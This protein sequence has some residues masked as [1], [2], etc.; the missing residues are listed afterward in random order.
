MLPLQT[1]KQPRNGPPAMACW[2][3]FHALRPDA[4]AER[5]GITRHD[6]RLVEPQ[7]QGVAVG[8]VDQ[9]VAMDRALFNCAVINHI[10]K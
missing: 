6:R 9:L 3:R 2:H 1:H 4:I 5:T 10:L 8:F 7:A